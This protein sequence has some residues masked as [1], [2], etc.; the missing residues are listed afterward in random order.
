MYSVQCTS[1]SLKADTA[2]EEDTNDRMTEQDKQKEYL[3]VGINRRRRRT[4]RT[5]E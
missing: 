3:S 2:E 5:R 4:K 1:L